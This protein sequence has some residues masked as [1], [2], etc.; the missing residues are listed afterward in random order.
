MRHSLPIAVVPRVLHR[1]ADTDPVAAS[2]RALVRLAA[3]VTQAHPKGPL[4]ERLQIIIL[5]PAFIG[6]IEL[7]RT[8]A[9]T[10]RPTTF[11]RQKGFKHVLLLP[12]GLG[13]KE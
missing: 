8:D 2:P 10:R 3:A 5:A 13:G 7:G 11:G 1:Q 4:F 6:A 9:G 12:V